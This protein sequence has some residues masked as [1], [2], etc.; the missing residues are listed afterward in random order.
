MTWFSPSAL[1]VDDPFTAA[2]PGSRGTQ[3]NR[4]VSRLGSAIAGPWLWGSARSQRRAPATPAQP[5]A[6]EA[7]RLRAPRDVLQR[8]A[9]AA[10]ALGRDESEVWVEAA[11]EWL[12]RHV[13][14]PSSGGQPAMSAPLA[15]SR[16]SQ[17]QVARRS[18]VWRDIDHL[19][20][21]LRDDARARREESG[22]A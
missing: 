3:H 6:P 14:E 11:R 15:A 2:G 12:M 1:M 16:A 7:V 19:L 17:S 10:D 22:V 21:R 13:A 18:L 9:G 20:A 8:M 5:L 4:R